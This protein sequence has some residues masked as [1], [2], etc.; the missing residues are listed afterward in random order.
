MDFDLVITNGTVIDGTGQPRFRADLGVQGG[1]IVAIAAGERLSGQQVLDAT[2]LIVA[3]GFIDVHSHSDWV[4]PLPGHAQTLAPLLLQG[5]TTLVTGNCGFSPAPF[6]DESRPLLDEFSEMLRDGPLPDEWRSMSEFLDAL[7]RDGLL[8]NAAFL[9]GHGTLRYAAMGRRANNSAPPTPEDM[10]N[11]RRIVRQTLREGAFGFS[12]GLAYAPC[13]F[14]HNDELLSL[15]RVV[16]QEGAIFTVHG[17][18]YTW[19]SPFYSPMIGGTPHNVR[20]VREL[21]SLAREA[22]VRLELSHQ[23]FVGRRTWRTHRTVL[24]DIERAAADGLDV[25][26]DAFPYTV[27]NSTISVVFPAWF[28]DGFDRNID[29]PR[30]LKRLKREINL[31][32]WTLG[33]SY[34]DITLL[35]ACAPELAWLEGLDF[36]AVARR[37][38]MSEFEAYV[39]VARV[40]GGRARVLLGTYSGDG[41]REEPLRAALS[42][43]LCSFMTDT[44]LT[45]RGK[46]NPASFGAFPRVLGKYSR[47]LGLFS[48]EE[49]VHRM[50]GLPAKRIGLPGV[51]RI[52]EGAQADL[53]LFDAATVADNTTPAQAD[54][55]PTGIRAVLISGQIVARDGKPVGHERLGRVLRR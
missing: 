4:L 21:L 47:D 24:R 52:A 37:L 20:S 10:D 5:I 19:V 18:A 38:G 13:V 35:W 49:A 26:F 41:E 30:A 31:L 12:T 39:H 44:I 40:S 50:T 46:H 42:N 36:G 1:Q 15:L 55:P 51:G 8:L 9:V 53:V 2:G 43:P 32:R 34:G 27:G 23:I 33:L 28:L 16:A 54:A 7:E 6:T 14:A 29:D 3:P 17:R 22:R 45:Q 48:L 25:A 11:M